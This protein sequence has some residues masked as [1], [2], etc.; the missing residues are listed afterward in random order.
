MR[1]VGAMNLLGDGS[2]IFLCLVCCL[3]VLPQKTAVGMMMDSNHSA[4]GFPP[5]PAG[6]AEIAKKLMLECFNMGYQ[7]PTMINFTLNRPVLVVEGIP[8]NPI[9]MFPGLLSSLPSPAAIPRTAQQ[10]NISVYNQEAEWNGT[11]KLWNCTSMPHLIGTM[12]ISTDNPRCFMR[13]FIGPLAW[14]TAMRNPINLDPEDLGKLLWAAKPFLKNM[15]PSNIT[16]PSRLPHT[17]VAEM[18]KLFSDIF[19][20]LSEDQKVQIGNWVKERVMENNFNCN[21]NSPVP[22]TPGITAPPALMNMEPQNPGMV[23]SVSTKGPRLLNLNSTQNLSTDSTLQRC[24]AKIPWLKSDVMRMMGPFVTRLPAEDIQ[25]IPS[26]ELCKFFQ[27]PQFASSFQGV[28]TI[29]PS[30]GKPLLQRLQS[31]SRNSQDFLQNSDRLGSLA[32]FFDGDASTMSVNLSARLL[33]QLEDCKNSASSKLKQQ[34][35][36][37]VLSSSE[38]SPGHELLKTLGSSV[39][40]LPPSKLERFTPEALQEILP[41]LSKN[42]WKPAQAST[43][44]KALLKDSKDVSAEQLLSLGTMVRGVASSVLQKVKAQELLG[45]KGLEMMSRTLSNLQKQALLKGMQRNESLSEILRTIPSPLLSTL[46][47]GT[48]EKAN[49]TSVDQLGDRNWTRPQSAYLLR[50]ILGKTINLN[51]VRKLGPAMQGL[52]CEMIDRI[53]QNYTIES[54]QA[55]LQ[56]PDWLSKSQVA[57]VAHKLTASLEQ[58]RVKYFSNVSLAELQKIP[59]QLLIHLPVEQITGLPDAVCG[60]FLE[61]MHHAN[62]SCLPQSSP[63]R[64]ALT[65]RALACLGKSLSTVSAEELQSLGQLLCEVGPSQLSLLLPPV[66]NSTLVALT[67]CSFRRSQQAELFQLVTKTFGKPSDWSEEMM[68]LLRPYLLLDNSTLRSL[69]YQPWLKSSLSELRDTLQSSSAVFVPEEFNSQPDL[70]TLRWKLFTLAISGISKTNTSRRRREVLS[71]L[72]PTASVIEELGEGNIFWSSTQLANMSAET[73][74]E[75][76]A[77]LGEIRDYSTE[78]LI[79]LRRKSIEVLGPIEALNETQVVELGCLCQSFTSEELQ[80]LNILSLDTLEMLSSCRWSDTQRRAVWQ[81][82]VQHTGMS[83]AGLGELEIVGLGQ[84]ICGLQQ[85]EVSQLNTAT[86]RE[87]VETIG[88]AICSLNMTEQ[89]KQLAVSVFGKPM[90]W[91]EGQVSTMGNIIASLNSTELQNLNASVLPFISSSAI[92]LIPPQRL[93]ALSPSQLKALGPDNAA[94]VTETQRASLKDDQRAALAE[95]LGLPYTRTESAPTEKPS[96]VPLKGGTSG[97]CA[98]GAVVLLQTVLLELLSLV[99]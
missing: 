42:Q 97:L 72:L 16:L 6:F 81:G 37:T 26:D 84:F 75:S 13:A 69:P 52:T 33:S 74:K 25:T 66:L 91:N 46:S 27:S 28:G 9:F 50:K 62:L 12:M 10:P 5:V 8:P 86:F 2:L 64:A 56:S 15:F 40:L 11:E 65:S 38:S 3:T 44:V 83:V 20:S 93:A 58:Q 87:A 60:A 79:A 85:A 34:L 95:A 63:S 49:L 98:F 23:N 73:F 88:R 54:A 90:T 82:F 30:L 57:C 48:L 92:P 94:M 53:S 22:S 43:L 21:Q 4:M 61:K 80:K 14:M 7:K 39:S 78:Q 31:C 59:T 1:S 89:F 68:N 32:C 51:D 29:N 70:S 17:H 55:L 99:Y 77:R 71:L 41:S 35:V 19:G 45:N 76:A 24:V 96:P 67:S 36:K 18:M 47:L